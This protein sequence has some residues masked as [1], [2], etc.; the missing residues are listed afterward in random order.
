M[1]LARLW[2]K[3]ALCDKARSALAAIYGAY[4]EGFTTPDL[5]DARL[6]LD[7]LA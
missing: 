2:Q 6:L 7:A 3:Q 5:I 4:T 1:S